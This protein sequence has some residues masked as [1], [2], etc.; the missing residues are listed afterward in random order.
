MTPQQRVLAA[1]AHGRWQTLGD[2]GIVLGLPRRAIEEAVEALRLE[3]QPVIGGNEGVKLTRD[4]LELEAYLSQ[5]RYRTAAIHRGT[6]AL[7]R[8]LREMRH[9]AQVELWP[10]A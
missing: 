3:G 7:R 5:R 1:L 4:P 2:L 9:G 10:A 8:T 6:M